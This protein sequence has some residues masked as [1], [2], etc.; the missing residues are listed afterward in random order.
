MRRKNLWLRVSSCTM[1]ALL[2]TTSVAP[3]SA[4]D[5]TSEIVMEDQQDEAADVE[6]AVIE[7]DAQADASAEVA[8]DTAE[9]DFADT[10]E[11]FTDTYEAEE[12]TDSA[13]AVSD[14]TDETT[15]TGF[16]TANTELAKGIYSVPASL[17][18]ATDTEKDSMA[19]SCIAG[20]ATL[21][22]AEDG[23]ARVTVPLQNVTVGQTTSASKDWKIY[24]G[25]TT[26]ETIDAEYTTDEEGNVNSITF[27]IPDKTT[28]GVYV[29]ITIA[30]MNRA[31]D[32]F[33]KLDYA[34]AEAVAVAVDTTELE[35]SIAK[36]EAL[37]EN[38]YTKATWDENKDAIAEALTAAKA[39]LEAKESQE[40]VDAAN[41]ALADAM[42]KLVEAGD[43]TE[44]KAKIEEAKALKETDYSVE[45][46]SN[47]W[48]SVQSAI[49][50]A[51]TAIENR[52][53]TA[54]LNSCK[55][56]INTYM[57]YLIKTKNFL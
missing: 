44:L 38:S 30:A 14:S 47:Y 8:A 43:P 39:A 10:E 35:A 28:D 5:F 20:T 6:A 49:T 31:Q 53:T 33:L 1:A 17:K 15:Q 45:S 27:T 22:V 54:K 34:K 24:K 41:T 56:S 18:N 26:T 2:A 40:T 25:D 4:A 51:E 37:E 46:V 11:A 55:S 16:G 3:V 7:E 12:F 9:A 19:A 21:K 42:G 23:T 29:N 36:A 32:A 57:G 48:N 50:N 52:E 13:E